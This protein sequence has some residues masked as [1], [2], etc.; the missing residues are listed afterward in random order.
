ME[1]GARLPHLQDLGAL[2]QARY[3]YRWRPRRERSSLRGADPQ[4][5]AVALGLHRRLQCRDH[6]GLQ[7]GRGAV[8]ALPLHAGG[9]DV[10]DARRV[11]RYRLRQL[12]PR[13]RGPHAALCAPSRP[14]RPQ[15]GAGGR[16]PPAVGEEIGLGRNLSAAGAC[17]HL[18]LPAQRATLS[19][20]YFGFA[21]VFVLVVRPGFQ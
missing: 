17:E 21:C 4:L 11:L 1:V 5:Q 16:V 10:Q 19:A 6:R 18:H 15:A 7:Q 13:Q 3:P 9:E 14:H 20:L 8:P 2:T 12:R